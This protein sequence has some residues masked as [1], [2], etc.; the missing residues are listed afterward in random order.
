MFAAFVV[1]LREGFEASLLV[2]IVLAYLT[3][4]GRWKERRQVWFGVGAA[5]VVSIVLGG[6][7]FATARE[8]SGPAE[9]LFEAC[10]L[11]LAVGF[12]TYMVLWMRRESRTISGSI[13]REVDSAVKRG[14]GFALAL[15]VFVMVLREGVETGLF[16]FGIS[17]ASTPLQTAIGAT[18]GVLAAVALGY[19]VYALGK[20]IN[21]GAFFRYTG[22]FI[23]VVAAGLL[24]QGI[25]NLQL[26]GLV[27]AFLYPLWDVSE[28]PVLGATGGLGQFLGILVGWDPRP[29]LL[30]FCAWFLYL[31]IVGYLFFRPQTTQEV[32]QTPRSARAAEQGA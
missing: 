7:L 29:D 21:L 1:L 11:L 27:P 14:S 18:A 30:E 26:A 4:I 32:G 16:V 12:L 25:V 6:V 5:L 23:I 13:R 17:R 22:A 8:L 20:S 9:K 31:L 2:A 24:A 3:R 19:A 15:L 10:A 28:M